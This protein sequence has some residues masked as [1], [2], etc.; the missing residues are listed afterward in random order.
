MTE[1]TKQPKDVTITKTKGRPMLTWVGK[2]PWPACAP[3]RRRPSN[4][5][6]PPAASPPLCTVATGRL[7]PDLPQGGLL[8]HGDNKDVLA[9]PAGNGFRG[10]VKLIYIDPPFDSG[11]DYVRK[12]NCAAPRARSRSMARTTLGEQV[13]LQRYLGERYLSAVYVWRLLMLKALL[14]RRG[15]GHALRLGKEPLTALRP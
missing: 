12:C 5:L 9:H 4:G 13:Q 8:Y 15:S 11:A 7:A 1:N 6:T 2:S 3:T 14:F 10:K